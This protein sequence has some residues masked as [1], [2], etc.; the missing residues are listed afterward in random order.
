MH[1]L[2]NNL[3]VLVVNE[4]EQLKEDRIKSFVN[5]STCYSDWIILS[6]LHSNLTTVNFE[7]FIDDLAIFWKK[8]KNTWKIHYWFNYQIDI[9]SS[10]N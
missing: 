10:V 1:F 3:S 8:N 5:T 7:N 9:L 6:F 2:F 4:T